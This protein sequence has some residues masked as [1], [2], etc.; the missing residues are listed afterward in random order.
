MVDVKSIPSAGITR[1]RFS[2]RGLVAASQPRQGLPLPRHSSHLDKA[3]DSL[4]DS[5][6]RIDEVGR[7][8]S[9]A[10]WRRI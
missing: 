1:I 3:T 2:G 9:S 6:Q 5:F 10:S 4:A 8:G 7:M